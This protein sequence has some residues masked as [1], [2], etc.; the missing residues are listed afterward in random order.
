[1]VD[2]FFVV[3]YYYLVDVG[4]DGGDCVGEGYWVVG[5]VL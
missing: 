4:F 2:F 5:L 1:M 3:F